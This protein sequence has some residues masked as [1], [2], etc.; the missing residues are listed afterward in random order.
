MKPF[1]E[2]YGGQ[3]VEELIAMQDR[4]RIDSLLCALEMGIEQSLARRSL[5][6]LSVPEWT[7]L[8]IEG[9]QREVNNGGYHQFFLNSSADYVHG[10]VHAMERIRTK[11]PRQIIVRINCSAISASHASVAQRSSRKTSQHSLH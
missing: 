4:Y 5:T 6:D 2:Q 3:T 10:I 1:L 8:A 7:L 9:L 11:A